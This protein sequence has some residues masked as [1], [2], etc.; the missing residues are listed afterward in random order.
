[1]PVRHG[2]LHWLPPV[3]MEI[4]PQGEPVEMDVEVDGE[5]VTMTGH[6]YPYSHLDG[7]L[8]VWPQAGGPSSAVTLEWHGAWKTLLQD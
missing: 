6:Y 3:R 4:P 5:T 1:M 2:E 7:G 8:F